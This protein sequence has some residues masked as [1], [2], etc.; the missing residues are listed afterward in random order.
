MSAAPGPE[1]LPSELPAAYRLR[2]GSPLDR[3]LLLQAMQQTYEELY[4][5]QAF[6]HLSSTIEAYLSPE[7]P[8]WWIEH[9]GQP[10]ADRTTAGSPIL[11]P[12]LPSLPRRGLVPRSSPVGSLWMG[13]AIDQVSGQRHSHIFLLYIA[14]EHRRL[15]LGRYLMDHAEAW[16]KARGDRH[17][18][19]Q[20]FAHNQPALRLYQRLGY[21][22]QSIA[23]IKNL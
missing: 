1:S 21:Q 2:V 11:S 15:G 18:S 7:T 13:T 22:T 17:I 14:P 5:G 23:L 6:N 9:E 10:E 19:L 12:V 20:V 8:L 3:A 16:A 4:P